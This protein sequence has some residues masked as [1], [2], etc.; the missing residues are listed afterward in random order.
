MFEKAIS[1][2]KNG[3]AIVKPLMLGLDGMKAVQ[4]M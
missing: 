4:S 1:N 3:M 2:L